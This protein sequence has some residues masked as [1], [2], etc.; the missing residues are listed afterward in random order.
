MLVWCPDWPVRATMRRE[1]LAAQAPVAVIDRGQVYAC[2][3]AARADGVRRGLRVRD[4][5]SRC[6]DLVVSTRDDSLALRVFEPIVA[7]IE[8]ISP[9]VQV[10]RPGVC[11]V[12][13]QGPARYYGSEQYAAA[14]LAEQVV[15]EGVDD[16]RL[17]IAD[18]PFT[19]EQAA[20]RAAIQDVR[21]IEPGGSAAFLAPLSIDL[22]DLPDLVGLLRRLGLRTLGAFAELPVVD[23][24]ARFGEEGLL[25]HRLAAGRETSE[26]DAR[27]PPPELVR[28]IEFEPP[29]DKLDEIAF[30][31]RTTAES[32]VAGLS[33]HGL[34]ATSVLVHV[35]SDRGELSERQWLHPRWFDVAE[36]VDRVRWQLSGLIGPGAPF[37][38]PVD[39]V[40]FEPVTVNPLADHADGLWGTAPDERIARAMSRVQ[41]MLGH[42]GVRVP[43]RGGGRGP[44]QRQ[45]Q[46][47]W[48]DQPIGL[49]DP[50]LPW[51]GRIPAP[52][53]STI[54][55]TPRPAA[56]LTGDG[57][58]V[59][60]TERGALSGDPVRFGPS[61]GA[62]DLRPIQAWA[63]PWPV[64]ERWW[65][66]KQ[67]R[68][69]ARLQVVGV[70][71]SAWLLLVEGGQW[72]VEASYE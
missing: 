63:G 14:V 61:A 10:I 20:R 21:I 66:P 28:S 46:V 58:T 53:P 9:G 54:Y 23:V 72:F 60:L 35:R 71:G 41:S 15:H 17:G 34:V 29:L 24:L 36:L 2:S 64:E 6:P 43:V 51:P 62:G 7:V 40:R 18:G 65:D 32:F 30:T 11:A 56:V 1:Q 4:A 68:S 13:A 50:D 52:A 44:A 12:R 69:L 19:A 16:L 5:Q 31:I 8:A 67:A 37:T 33:A 27:K 26:L 70:D 22:I 59:T 48:G 25:A 57:S 55:P 39:Q 42:E 49:R 3:P 38:G 47:A 45:V